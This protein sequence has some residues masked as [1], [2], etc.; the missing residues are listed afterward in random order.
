MEEKKL[1]D[2]A[3]RLLFENEHVK[4]WEMNL[5]PGEASDFHEHTMPYVMCVVHGSSIDA[6]FDGGDTMK[7]P[8]E[9]G[10]VF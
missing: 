10:T 4:V 3:N 8:V 7:I 6:D 2:V 9:P 5:Q 1:G